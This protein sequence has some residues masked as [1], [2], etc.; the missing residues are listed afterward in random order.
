MSAR[1]DFG[2]DRAVADALEPFVDDELRRDADVLEALIE[3]ERVR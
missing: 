2:F 1:L 3:L